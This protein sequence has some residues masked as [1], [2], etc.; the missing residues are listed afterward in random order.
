MD[1]GDIKGGV[2]GVM[3]PLHIYYMYGNTRVVHVYQI[4]VYTPVLLYT[5][6]TNTTNVLKMWHN[7][8]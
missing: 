4:N 6:Q 8:P 5:T 2:Y 7:W 3:G 1:I